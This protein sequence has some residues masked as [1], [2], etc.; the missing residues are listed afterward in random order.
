[1]DSNWQKRTAWGQP[2][3]FVWF[4]VSCAAIGLAAGTHWRALDIAFALAWVAFLVV[5]SFVVLWRVWKH[6]SEPGTVKLGQLAAL[7]RNWRLWVLGEAGD[8]NSK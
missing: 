5:G 8:G 4:F 7:P 1:M 3:A 6:H 2:A